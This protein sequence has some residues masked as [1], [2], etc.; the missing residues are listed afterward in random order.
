MVVLT[1]FTSCLSFVLS[2]SPASWWLDLW[3]GEEEGRAPVSLRAI[4]LM[5]DFPDVTWGSKYSVDGANPNGQF[6][7]MCFRTSKQ[8]E[9]DRR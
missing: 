7:E 3:T 6:C 2:F 5:E 8:G 4:H 9:P 1:V